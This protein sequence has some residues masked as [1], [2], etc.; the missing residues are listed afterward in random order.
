MPYKIE[1]FKDGYRLVLIKDPSHYF[2]NH[3]MT[4]EQVIKQ[5]QAIEIGKRLRG[6]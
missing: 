3:P 4:K 1:K 5:M 2:S 6:K